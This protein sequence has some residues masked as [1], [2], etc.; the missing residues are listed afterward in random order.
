MKSLR[1]LGVATL[2][3]IVALNLP[4]P[5]PAATSVM[6]AAVRPQPAN[7]LSVMTYNVEG[8]PFPAAYGRAGKLAEIGER[9]GELRG[10]GRQPHVVL[11]QEAFIPQAKAIA[12]A[13]G[14]T[15]V[16][17]GPQITD[18]ST[19]S[20]LADHAF[21]AQASWVNGEDLGKWVDSGLV[22][23]SD[24]PIVQTR[25]MAFPADMCAGFD[26]LAAKG[27]LLAWV[28]IPGHDLP[29]AIADTHLNSRSASG[30]AVERAN[31]A[32]LRQITAVRR[33][34]RANVPSGTD[35]IFGGDFNIGH[36]KERIAAEAADGGI[37][38][39]ANEATL[40]ASAI[41]AS[42]MAQQDRA[43]ILTR[44]KD[45]QYFRAGT[46]SRLTL[47]GLEVPFGIGN[48]GNELSDHL[49][50]VAYYRL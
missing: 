32:Y 22:I 37:V 47:H 14:Y 6:P 44:A 21:N 19:A 25:R 48:G 28:K 29:I 33:F 5:A 38:H 10:A 9:L 23:L 12:K 8:L 11:L 7:E 45:K 16:A 35:I 17:L 26:C 40:A 3:G 2:A 24:Y 27:V 36:D 46:D 39:G 50:Y 49:G 15:H 41:N 34:I 42:S 43:A 13:A 4:L 20:T 18:A 1:M 31:A 30:V